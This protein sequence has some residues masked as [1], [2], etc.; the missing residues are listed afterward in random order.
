[1]YTNIFLF[2]TKSNP[3]RNIKRP[4]TKIQTP[5]ILKKFSIEKI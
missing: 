2:Y 4:H 3:L 5:L 1:M